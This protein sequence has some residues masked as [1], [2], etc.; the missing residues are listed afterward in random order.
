M[1]AP[2]TK[3]RTAEDAALDDAFR[4]NHRQRGLPDVPLDV[5]GIIQQFA[6]P[7]SLEVAALLEPQ[8]LCVD[9]E[10]G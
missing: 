5:Q 1:A 8:M 4:E 3:K 6:G 9:K 10:W 2:A 7:T